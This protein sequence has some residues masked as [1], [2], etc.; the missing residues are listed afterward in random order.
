MPQFGLLAMLV[1]LPLQLL[2]GSF[3]PR[4]SMPGFVRITM[5][6]APTTHF[7]SLG[8]GICRGARLE[9]VGCRCSRWPV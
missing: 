1:L 6:A 9:M 3:T 5:L 7:V 4:E 8:Q 2:S